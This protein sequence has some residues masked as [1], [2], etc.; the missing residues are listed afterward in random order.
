VRDPARP[1]RRPTTRALSVAMPVLAYI[2]RYNFE[3]STKAKRDF[4]DW[5]Q[6][7]R[8]QTLARL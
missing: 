8:T 4:N 5:T 1:P 7:E 3:M 6:R 2:W